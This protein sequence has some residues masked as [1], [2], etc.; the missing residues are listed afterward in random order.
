RFQISLRG[1]LERQGNVRDKNRV[2]GDDTVRAA[3]QDDAH[4]GAGFT[5]SATFALNLQLSA[6]VR[7]DSS[8]GIARRWH[9]NE[10]PV[11]EFIPGRARRQLLGQRCHVGNG[12]K[13]GLWPASPSCG[14]GS[15]EIRS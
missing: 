7:L 11:I 12:P 3:T 1:N 10:F 15:H 9:D 14:C 13:P 4:L 6:N 5:W 8:M 2:G